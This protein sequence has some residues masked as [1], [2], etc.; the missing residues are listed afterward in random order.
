MFILDEAD[1][2]LSLG[3]KDQ[4]YDIF[5]QM[6]E[7]VQVILLSATM[8]PSVLEITKSFMRNP[9]KILIKNEEV[10]LEGILQYYVNAER[11]VK[12]SSS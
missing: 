1:E 6:P 12:Y 11:E 8:P 5:T 9:I 10:T 2:M 3:F 7:T 4:I